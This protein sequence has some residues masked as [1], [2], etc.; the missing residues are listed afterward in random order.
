LASC[1]FRMSSSL[2]AYLLGP[3]SKVRARHLTW[4]QSTSFFSLGAATAGAG[5]AITATAAMA[6]SEVKCRDITVVSNVTG[7]A[8]DVPT[9][10]DQLSTGEGACGSLSKPEPPTPTATASAAQ[11]SENP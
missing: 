8:R 7:D 10:A 5:A 6:K 4:V 9:V 11:P 1:F 3:S 2:P